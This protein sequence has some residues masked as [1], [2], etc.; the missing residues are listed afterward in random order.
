MPPWVQSCRR[1]R[2]V[3][4]AALLL[5]RPLWDQGGSTGRARPGSR[6]AGGQLRRVVLGRSRADSI[7]GLPEL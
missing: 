1:A 5:S 6:P 7:G 2:P 4:L 3:R